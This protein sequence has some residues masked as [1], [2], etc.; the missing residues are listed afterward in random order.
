MASEKILVV[1]DDRAI[2]MALR[3]AFQQE[4]MSVT[5]ADSGTMALELLQ[6]QAFHLIILDIMMQDMDGFS[7]LQQ[8]RYSGNTT[9]VLIL[10]G[11]S[12]D[13]DQVLGLGLGADDYLTKPFH[14]AI[15]IQKA[16]ALIRRSTVYN[17]G[18]GN[19]LSVPPFQ[20]DS[21]KLECTKSG[22]PITFTARELA[23]FRF[24][25]ENPGQVYSKEQLYRMVWNDNVVDDNTITVY[26]KRIREKIEE[27]MKN[28]K[29]I[30]TVR[31]VGYVFTGE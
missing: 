4:K 26:M 28:P 14:V 17:A 1:D 12:E 3:A 16:K 25:M 8:I 7:T 20:F 5:E 10:S 24:L 27:D 21:T 13:V 22:E 9:P 23:L 29:Y 31:G 6:K 2:R 11:K 15:L 30:R 18:T 19:V